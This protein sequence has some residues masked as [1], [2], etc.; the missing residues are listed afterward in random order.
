MGGMCIKEQNKMIHCCEERPQKNICQHLFL[1]KDKKPGRGRSLMLGC[2]PYVCE[3][4]S[5]SPAQINE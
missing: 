4:L 5:P 2:L 3:A 1:C